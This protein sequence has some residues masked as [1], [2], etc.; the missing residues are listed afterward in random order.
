[1]VP[2]TRH[3]LKN[4]KPGTKS[5]PVLVRLQSAHPEIEEQESA[6]RASAL[7]GVGRTWI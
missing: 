6:S 5:I 4:K 2:L 3:D 7:Q 1:L